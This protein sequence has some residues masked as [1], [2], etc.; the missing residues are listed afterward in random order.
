MKVSQPKG[1]DFSYYIALASRCR[2]LI[3]VPFCLVIG[4]GSYLAVTLPKTYEAT[5]LILVQ[6]QRVPERLVTP[7]VSSS[8]LESRI[9]TISQQILSRSNLEKVIER[10]RLFSGSSQGEMLM[11]DKIASLRQRIKIEVSRTSSR[12]DAE[13]FSLGFRDGDPS[14]AM[15]VTNGLATFFIDENLK[16]REGQAV[17][18]S[19]FLEAELQSM[20]KRLEEKE[21]ALKD[22]RQRNMGELPEQLQAN[23]NLLDRLNAQLSQSQASLRTA[24][25]SLAALESEDRVRQSISVSV[26]GQ[27]ATP[28]GR[29]SE[30]AMTLPQLKERLATL[31][32][33]YTDQHP[34]VVR[35][36]TRIEKM[37]TERASAPPLPA[38]DGAQQAPSSRLLRPESANQR[39]MIEGTIRVLEAEIGRIVREIREIQKK[40]DATPNREQELLTFHRDYENI[41]SSYNSL[42]NR[43]LEADISVNM[44]KKQKGEQFQIIDSARLPEKPVSP[45]PKKLFMITVAV[46][47][48]LGFGVVFLVDFLDSSIRRVDE[49]EENFGLPVLATVP[50]IFSSRDRSLNRLNRYATTFSLIIAF[51]LTA[52]FAALCFLGGVEPV[53]G[54]L[55]QYMA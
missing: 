51:T 27:G 1:F 49:L 17:G 23:L 31:R 12:R 5:T 34:D 32:S 45:D 38:A 21:Q 47:L 44:E 43:K 36:R 53:V 55:R 13:A 54:I 16:M 24:Q 7:V 22:Y 52:S 14:M 11:E 15:K 6:P 41:K 48:G 10:F 42:L 29:E 35:L 20:R 50:R 40:V 28:T 37:Q 9:S 3:I 4:I 39:V 30:D 19:D 26:A 18:T 46:A 25:I 33:N 8:D 2:W